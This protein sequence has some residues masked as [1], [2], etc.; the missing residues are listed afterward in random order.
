MQYGLIP[1][2][3]IVNGRP[4]KY[5]DSA[6]NSSQTVIVSYGMLWIFTFTRMY[7]WTY[8]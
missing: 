8:D 3:S 5:N 4:S 6:R 1:R 7:A 2:F